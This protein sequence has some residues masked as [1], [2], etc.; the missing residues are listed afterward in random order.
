MSRYT[1][2]RTQYFDSAGDPLIS[3]KLF[4][5]NS[6]TS[7][8]KTT[9][10]DTS[11]TIANQN[12]VILTGDGRVPNIFFTGAARVKLTDK[13]NVQIFDVDPVGGA[14]TAGQFSDYDNETIYG[15]GEIVIGSDGNYYVSLSSGNQSNDPT[16]SPTF[17]LQVEFIN[18]WNPNKTFGLN[19]TSKASDGLLYRSLVASNTGND[20]VSSPTQWGFPVPK[21]Q[22]ADITDLAVTTDKINN[23]AV[24]TEKIND[25]AVTLDKLAGG[26]AGNLISFDASGDP[27]AVATGTALEVLTSNGAGLPPTM[28]APATQGDV[29]GP[30][31][32]TDNA[33]ATYDGTTGKLLKDG[34]IL[35]TAATLNTGV[36]SGDV[37]LVG[38]KSSTETLAGLVE[39][40][41]SAENVTGTDDT[42]NPTVAGVKEMIDTHAAIKILQSITSAVTANSGTTL[43]PDDNTTPLISAGTEVFSQVITPGSTSNTILIMGSISVEKSAGNGVNLVVFRGSVCIGTYIYKDSAANVPDAVPIHIKDEPATE[44]ATTYSIRAGGNLAG[45]WRVNQRSPAKYNGTMAL[46]AVT[47]QEIGA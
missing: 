18:I 26:T 17:W 34:V 31:S 44:S 2:P 10:A 4:F 39:K 21:V 19:E 22:T 32:A 24:T 9:F 3:G 46:S 8:E 30:A 20:P 43:I 29:V 35:G 6:G 12:P 23:S 13:D 45:T 37:P 33:V 27:V 11:E 47:I 5:F 38:T 15:S 7:T 1:D 36:A 16:T 28:Q 41:T 14:T 42:V 40:S 25:D